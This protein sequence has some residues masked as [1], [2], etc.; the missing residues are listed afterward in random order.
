M[1]AEWVTLADSHESYCFAPNN[2]YWSALAL[3]TGTVQVEQGQS[4]DVDLCLPAVVVDKRSQMSVRLRAGDDVVGLAAVT[5]GDGAVSAP[6]R[7]MG[8]VT[9]ATGGLR[10]QAEVRGGGWVRGAV[11]DGKPIGPALRYRIV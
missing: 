10:V 9:G 7:L 3:L 8:T 1:S 11:V 5:T 4:L 6:V 2:N